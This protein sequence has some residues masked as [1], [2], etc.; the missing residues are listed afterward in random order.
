MYVYIY[1]YIYI[2]IYTC[3]YV[4]IYINM[5]TYIHTYSFLRIHTTLYDLLSRSH[6][7][8]CF[9]KRAL[10]WRAPCAKERCDAGLF[11]QK[12]PGI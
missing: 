12:N 1:M 5:Y 8:H 2:Y 6:W 9:R 10:W 7:R 3:I 4:Y 11:P